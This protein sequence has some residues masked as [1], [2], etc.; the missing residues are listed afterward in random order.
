MWLLFG[1]LGCGGANSEAKQV[2]ETL[3][4]WGQLDDLTPAGLPPE[5]DLPSL[6]R[7]V[8]L[9]F[10]REETGQKP[11]AD[12]PFLALHQ[13]V[14]MVIDD[15]IL[16]MSTALANRS[17]C[18]VEMTKDGEIYRAHVVRTSNAPT[19][20]RDMVHLKLREVEAI[21]SL[22]EKIA[23]IE[24]WLAEI[25]PRESAD[26]VVVEKH[27]EK[28]VANLGLPESAIAEAQ[29]KL[30]VLDQQI[31]VGDTAKA[32]LSKLTVLKTQYWQRSSKRS[33]IPRLEITVHN[34]TQ[35]TIGRIDFQ[36][37]LTSVEPPGKDETE[38][39]T[40][41]WVKG[42]LPVKVRGKFVPDST[43]TFT[44][45]SLLPVKWRTRAPDGAT[46]DLTPIRVADSAGNVV[47]TVDGLDDAKADAAVL[48]ERIADL[49]SKYSTSPPKAPE[50]PPASG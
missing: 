44:I 38:P 14:G 9:R 22:P 24:Q 37:T 8:D 46:V 27:G 25:P 34:G 33:S 48:R 7:E 30:D 21:P 31:A 35:L 45:V 29:A 15:P 3:C 26:D 41:V 4:R 23:R 16:A 17:Q 36:G 10:A 43:E 19:W 50:A 2:V 6:V 13:T 49:K 12:N 39:K 18:S 40:R 42:E 20:D 28:W 32:E 47:H 1:V 11:S 5:V